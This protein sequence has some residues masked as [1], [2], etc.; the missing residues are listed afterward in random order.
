MEYNNWKRLDLFLDFEEN[1]LKKYEY[2]FKA[3]DFN[4]EKCN[5]AY[6]GCKGYNYNS[7]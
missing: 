3:I 2:Y 1:P 4:F 7:R 5:L 6:K